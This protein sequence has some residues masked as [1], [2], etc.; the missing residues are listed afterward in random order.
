M[1]FLKPN[2]LQCQSS[3]GDLGGAAGQRDGKFREGKLYYVCYACRASVG[4]C[5]V[6]VMVG[7][8]EL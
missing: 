8:S 2:Q 6:C 3:P 5:N 7:W 4:A 1:I